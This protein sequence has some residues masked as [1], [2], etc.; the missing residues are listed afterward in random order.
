MYF[1]QATPLSIPTISLVGQKDSTA[2][3]ALQLPELEKPMRHLPS[4]LVRFP[5]FSGI[6]SRSPPSRLKHAWHG[7]NDPDIW[8]SDVPA[9]PR[10]SRAASGGKGYM[11]RGVREDGWHQKT[12]ENKKK[13]RKKTGKK[14]TTGNPTRSRMAHTTTDHG[15]A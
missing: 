9:Q 7:P 5:S 15:G 8:N 10:G 13:R 11:R 3:V 6:A 12:Q 14:R 2:D 1:A 4:L